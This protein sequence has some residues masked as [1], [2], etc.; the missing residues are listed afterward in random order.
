[1]YAVSSKAP[2]PAHLH[3]IDP[4][5]F[6]HVGKLVA[7]LHEE[8]G[9]KLPPDALLDEHSSAYNTLIEQA[10]D[11]RDRDELV[12]LLTWLETRLRKKLKAAKAEPGSGKQQA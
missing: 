4:I 12:S 6:K 11:P 9:I 3:T 2:V 8:Q 5:V 7:N 10:E 1:M